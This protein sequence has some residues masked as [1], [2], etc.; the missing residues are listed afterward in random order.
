MRKRL[1]AILFAVVVALTFAAGAG[2]ASANPGNGSSGNNTI[3]TYG[4]TW[5]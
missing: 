3:T 4:V 2:E 5:E 1:A